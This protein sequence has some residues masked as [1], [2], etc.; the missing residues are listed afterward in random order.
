MPLRD[1]LRELRRRLTFIAL[2]LTVGAV[3]G[4]FVYDPVFALLQRPILDLAEAREQT[5]ALNFQ[6]VATSFDMRIKVSLFLGVILS[7]PWW[8]YQLWAFITPGLTRRER[9]YAVAFLGAA[10][11]LFLGGAALAWWVLPNAVALL[12]EFTPDEATNL[13]DAQLYLSFVMRVILAFGVAFLLPVVMVAL[14]LAGLVRAR[15]WAVGWRWAVLTAFVF[16][17]IATPTPDVVTMLSVAFP[18]C[19]LYFLA[20]GVCVLHDRR[21]DRALVAQGLP[22]LDGTLADEDAATA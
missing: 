19:I 7:S 2:G 20:L 16:A 6:G 18:V 22:R 10:V 8:I 13:I 17:A 5:V 3:V 4:W 15:T 14:N 12:T 11:P 1:H 9:T 21:V